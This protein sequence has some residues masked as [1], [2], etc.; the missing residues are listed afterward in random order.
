METIVSQTKLYSLYDEGWSLCATP[1]GQKTL[2][3][4]QSKGMAQLLA[5]DKWATYQ[6]REILL[7]DFIDQVIPYLR[8]QQTQLS[9]NLMPE[10]QN[11]Q[12]TPKQFLIDLKSYLYHLY[13]HEPQ[14][15][16]GN[17]LP[18]PRKIRIND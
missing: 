9:L 12:I 10:G 5:R 17:V 13:I 2:A 11:V 7:T 18:S 1:S 16:H 4:W 14:R 3:V 15:F 8:Q 6:V